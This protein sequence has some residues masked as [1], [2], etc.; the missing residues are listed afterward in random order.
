MANKS[1]V[2]LTHGR[3]R[4]RHICQVRGGGGDGGRSNLRR[5]FDKKK[6][7]NNQTNKQTNKQTYEGWGWGGCSILQM[8]GCNLIAIVTVQQ[9]KILSST[10]DFSGVGCGGGWWG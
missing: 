8:Y 2:C 6:K 7:T 4:P 5:K 10:G 3:R 1:L 9:I